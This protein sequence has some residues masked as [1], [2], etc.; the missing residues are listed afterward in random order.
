METTSFVNKNFIENK[1]WRGVKLDKTGKKLFAVTYGS[2]MY[3]ANNNN[4]VN[5]VY[6]FNLN[7]VFVDHFV[8]HN[9]KRKNYSTFLFNN[10]SNSNLKVK[11]F[12][13]KFNNN[14]NS[15]NEFKFSVEHKVFSFQNILLS[16]L[17]FTVIS[18]FLC[19]KNFKK[20]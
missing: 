11:T 13:E 4:I 1:K 7:T 8:D 2:G 10:D 16:I 17:V 14:N 18:C 5:N 9:N 12:V 15:N 6:N 20:K 19:F 3:I